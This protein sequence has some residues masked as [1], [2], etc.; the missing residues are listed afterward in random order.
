MWN[1]FSLSQR[2][3]PRDNRHPGPAHH[4]RLG[5]RSPADV[6]HLGPHDPLRHPH[7]PKGLRALPQLLRAADRVVQEQVRS[8]H[9]E[10]EDGKK[11]GELK[12]M[13]ILVLYVK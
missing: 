8:A 1:L 6:L 12:L 4:L 2:I 5:D 10:A 9:K 11:G 13:L 3:Q 7:V